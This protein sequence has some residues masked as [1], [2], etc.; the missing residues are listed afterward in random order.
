[1]LRR[2]KRLSQRMAEG[3][4]EKNRARWFYAFSKFPDDGYADRGR[5]GALD[6]PLYQPHGLVADASAGRED[7]AVGPGFQG[8]PSRLGRGFFHQ[9]LDVRPVDVTHE[10]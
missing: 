7:D 10:G 5:S 8:E 2:V 4:F 6:F 3:P 9:R 1:M